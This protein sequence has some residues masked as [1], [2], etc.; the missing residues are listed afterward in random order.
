MKIMRVSSASNPNLV[1]QALSNEL[2]KNGGVEIEAIGA[3]AVNQTVKAMAVARG[4]LKSCGYDLFF[5][6]EFMEVEKEGHVRTAL[7]F[8]VSKRS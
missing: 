8:L 7:K 2:K 1:A 6:P 5:R 3:G 4:L